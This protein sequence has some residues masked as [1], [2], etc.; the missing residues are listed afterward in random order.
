MSSPACPPA[1]PTQGF[2]AAT[3]EMRA[4]ESFRS[5]FL[6]RYPQGVVMTQYEYMSKGSF[7]G[8]GGTPVRIPSKPH[9]NALL[10][11]MSDNF[12][13]H[14]KFADFR[15]PDGI[16]MAE[17][18][19]SVLV[20]L[21]EVTTAGNAISAIKQMQDKTAILM[22]TVAKNAAGA[23]LLDVK[24]TPWRPGKLEEMT[25]TSPAPGE[26]ARWV[27]YAPTKRMTPPAGVTLYE[28]HSVKKGTAVPVFS[29]KAQESL[30]KSYQQNKEFAR[31]G[32]P[33]PQAD[34]AVAR[35]V[36]SMLA[37]YGPWLVVGAAA[38]ACLGTAMSPVP[39]DEMVV[40]GF[41]VGVTRAAMR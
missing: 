7:A 1:V 40:C 32:L 17:Q 13:R 3:A 2:D 33:I 36:G 37:K 39:G 20:E 11:S 22:G 27:C 31:R 4:Y 15:K 14:V 24:G 41:A 12:R 21:L 30:Q 23:F 18:G 6:R 16:G 38:V 9:I 34:P 19:G 26:L 10:D 29:P 25:P 8:A 35:E 28:M 5:D